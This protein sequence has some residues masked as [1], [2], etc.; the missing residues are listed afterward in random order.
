MNTKIDISNNKKALEY[1]H[2]NRE[3]V[4]IYQFKRR[5]S[6]V[7][8]KYLEAWIR[9][10]H[11]LKVG[12][13]IDEVAESILTHRRALLKRNIRNPEM[14]EKHKLYYIGDCINI[15]KLDSS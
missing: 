9:M 4:R 7:D 6:G 15:E 12:A 5:Y 2:N 3:K 13:C 11:I 10:N 1:Y 8:D 14:I